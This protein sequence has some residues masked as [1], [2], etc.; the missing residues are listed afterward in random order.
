MKT[1]IS[2]NPIATIRQNEAYI[3]EI[4]S[5]SIVKQFGTPIFVYS[6]SKIRKNCSTFFQ[7]FHNY[8]PNLLVLYSYKANFLPQI[9]EIIN[10][11]GIGAEI[12]TKFELELA[13]KLKVNPAK[14]QL[15]GV[16]LPDDTLKLAIEKE[17]GLISICSINQLFNL[18]ELL[19]DFDRTQH[20]GLRM[21]SALQ[22][23]PSMRLN[24]RWCGK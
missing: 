22:R 24:G 16:Y 4:S 17:I 9:C 11:E 20:I 14:I 19:K 1:R 5:K 12:V 23:N 18:G 8:F 15:G 10:S 21:G 2:G 13:I 3:D 7:K 6:E